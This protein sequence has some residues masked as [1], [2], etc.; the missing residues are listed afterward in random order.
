MPT[1]QSGVTLSDTVRW[2]VLITSIGT[3]AHLLIGYHTKWVHHSEQLSQ[4]EVLA[5]SP[6]CKDIKLRVQ[7][8][9]VNNCGVAERAIN[10]GMLSPSVLAL[11]ETLQELSLCSGGNNDLARQT[12]SQNRCDLVIK[13]LIDSS[14]KV[15]L[16]A[17][18]LLVALIW[19]L[20]QYAY[21]VHTR[22]TKLPLDDPNYPVAGH[23]APW[24]KEALLKED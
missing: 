6:L 3:T 2:L 8:A 24:L 15:L 1:A 14:A 12:T 17:I 10:G 18:L 4:Y 7:S 16:L 23:M 20:R 19:F 13:A 22:D 11:L 9:E 21:I 5:G